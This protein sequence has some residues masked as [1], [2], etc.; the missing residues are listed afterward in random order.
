MFNA[1]KVESVPLKFDKIPPVGQWVTRGPGEDPL[2]LLAFGAA[3]THRINLYHNMIEA[4]RG[5]GWRLVIATGAPARRTPTV[6]IPQVCRH[7][8]LRVVRRWH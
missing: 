8:S 1:V 6:A 5:A 4:L 2:T 3:Y 7:R